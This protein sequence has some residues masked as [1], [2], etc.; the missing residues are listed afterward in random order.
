MFLYYRQVTHLKF[1]RQEVPDRFKEKISLQDHQKAIN[2]FFEKVKVRIFST[3]VDY[4]LIL[5]LTTGGLIS[6]F[7][8]SFTGL[9]DFFLSSPLLGSLLVFGTVGLLSFITSLPAS[10]YKQFVIETKFGFNNMSY[11]TFCSDILKG[12]L[13]AMIIG[14]PFLFLLLWLISQRDLLGS[15]WWVYLW[16]IVSLFSMGV[17]VFYPVLIAP[18]FNKFSPLEDGKLRTRLESL[19]KRCKFSSAG[20]FLMDGSRRSNH[21]NAFFAGMGKARRIVLFDTLVSKLSH[22]EIEAVL[23]HELG[24][25]KCGHVPMNIIT[26]LIFSFIIFAAFGSLIDSNEFYSGLGLGGEILNTQTVYGNSCF[27][28]VFFLVLPIILFPFEPLTSMLSRKHEFEAD[29]YAAKNSRAEDL[30][31]ALVKLYRDNASPVTTDRWFSLFFDSH[32][33]ASVRINTLETNQGK[34]GL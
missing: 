27:M 24:H 8:F 17:Q 30:I 13:L 28:I 33:P 25:Y 14:G 15:L 9:F 11:K 6:Y 1:N 26:N 16:I 21:G 34:V 10:I 4:L 22:S 31:S 3:V 32:P 19:L 5:V 18:I 20:L 23:A 29:N 12:M 7:V 2:Y